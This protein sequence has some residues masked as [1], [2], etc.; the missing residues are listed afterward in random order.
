[1]RPKPT[2]RPPIMSRTVLRMGNR[3]DARTRP[4]Q[5]T[6][7]VGCY[8]EWNPQLLPCSPA[9]TG[10]LRF[11][12]NQRAT[13]KVAMQSTATSVR[14]EV[15]LLV[16]EADCSS[17]PSHTLSSPGSSIVLTSGLNGGGCLIKPSQHWG[18]RR[19]ACRR[20]CCCHLRRMY[21]EVSVS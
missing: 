4:V 5:A 8:W 9:S 19:A 17:A 21:S 12:L 15:G 13:S 7:T 1:M 14:Q 10:T 16:F 11:S 18:E 3:L 2:Q 6:V 20:S